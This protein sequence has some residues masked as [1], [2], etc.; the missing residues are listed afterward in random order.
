M[1]ISLSLLAAC[2][3][4]IGFV[5]SRGVLLGPCPARSPC[6]L[7]VLLCPGI[8]FLEESEDASVVLVS[9]AV[10]FGVQAKGRQVRL[11]FDRPHDVLGQ[12]DGFQLD[13]RGLAHE[14][15]KS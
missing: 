6:F 10:R 7:Q 1:R 5:F 14:Q 9:D 15:G 2:R 3:A 13:M 8:V 12:T 4:N 11:G